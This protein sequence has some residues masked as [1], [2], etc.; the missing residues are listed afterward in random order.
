MTLLGI[1]FFFVL[2]VNR[3]WIGPHA[4]VALGGIASAIVFAAGLE[5]KRRY[6]TTY[7]TLAAVGAGIAGGYATLLSAAALYHMLSDW[8]ALLIAVGIAAVGLATSS[9]GARRSSPG[10]DCSARCSSPPSSW[11]RAA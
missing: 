3:G 6:G 5:L 7:S 1:I 4:R 8:A 9:P 10:S 11:R 2:A